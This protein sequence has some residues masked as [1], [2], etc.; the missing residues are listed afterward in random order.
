LL[1]VSVW[2][3]RPFM[4]RW[5]CGWKAT[6]VFD[7]HAFVAL[8]SMHLQTSFWPYCQ[9]SG[10]EWCRKDIC[11]LGSQSIGSPLGWQGK[12]ASDATAQRYSVAALNS[13]DLGC[14]NG[15]HHSGLKCEHSGSLGC[16]NSWTSHQSK[17]GQIQLF[18]RDRSPVSTD[19]SRNAWSF[20]RVIYFFILRAGLKGCT[21]LIR[22][23]GA[24]LSFLAL[25][26]HCSVF[27]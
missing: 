20:E 1:A 18:G 9:I 21:H 17:V 23:L 3:L 15:T 7:M 11:L 16:C 10:F 2:K 25:L 5:I 8:G 13:T 19:C 27:W 12:M 4:L 6:S 22:Q 14:D 26:D 24:Q